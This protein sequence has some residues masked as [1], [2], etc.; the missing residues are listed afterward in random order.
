MLRL[1]L[2]MTITL[3]IHNLPE[4]SLLLLL[5]LLICQG[6]HPHNTQLAGGEP[7]VLY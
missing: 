5:L 2:L 6:S 7:A 4:V 1:G 3:T